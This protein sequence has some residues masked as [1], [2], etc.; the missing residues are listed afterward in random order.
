M[1]I[2]SFIDENSF[3]LLRRLEHEGLYQ[4]FCPSIQY[5][6]RDE[7][8]TAASFSVSVGDRYLML[9][10]TCDDWELY[11]F[12]IEENGFPFGIKREKN[13]RFVGIT[14]EVSNVILGSISGVIR[15]SILRKYDTG[16]GYEYD[17]GI[18]LKLESGQSLLFVV[19]EVIPG[20]TELILSETAILQ[21][22]ANMDVRLEW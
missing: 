2:Q 9:Y 21:R 7:S 4:I 5:D 6:L 14:Q 19:S 17:A 13:G 22:I 12:F 20:L 3:P 15:T 10:S 8:F 18:L 1:L 16:M 11:Q